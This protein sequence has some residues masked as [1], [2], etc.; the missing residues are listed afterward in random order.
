MYENKLNMKTQRQK[1][2]YNINQMV[3]KNNIHNH[4]CRKIVT[5]FKM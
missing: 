1:N 4:N 3:H 2:K 5:M